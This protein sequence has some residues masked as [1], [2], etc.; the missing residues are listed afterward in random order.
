[1]LYREVREIVPGSA[2]N[3]TG[4]YREVRILVPG[5]AEETFLFPQVSPHPITPKSV[6]GSAGQ[7]E[8]RQ[9]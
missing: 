4:S 9:G 1:M 5:S 7:L 2:G 3:R 8:L 6:P